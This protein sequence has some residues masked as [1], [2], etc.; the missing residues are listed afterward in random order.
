MIAHFVSAGCQHITITRADVRHL[1]TQVIKFGFLRIFPKTVHQSVHRQC[2]HPIRCEL[3]VVVRTSIANLTERQG[4]VTQTHQKAIYHRLRNRITMAN[5]ETAP[6][7]TH[8]AL[9]I[10][11]CLFLASSCLFMVPSCLFMRHSMHYWDAPP[12]NMC[13]FISIPHRQ[14]F[15]MCATMVVAAS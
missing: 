11:S 3:F 5:T 15:K 10:S 14:K 7:T 4:G 9:L 8:T 12:S 1:Q 13:L 2:A 6:P